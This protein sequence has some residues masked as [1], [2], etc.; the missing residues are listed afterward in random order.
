MKT[1]ILSLIFSITACLSVITANAQPM[2][3]GGPSFANFIGS[4][5]M[6][7]ITAGVVL[8]IIIALLLNK[9]NNKL[10]P[11]HLETKQ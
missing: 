11:Q 2:L 3:K 1:I 6:W 4:P 9:K 8:L 7:V 5:G 10:Q